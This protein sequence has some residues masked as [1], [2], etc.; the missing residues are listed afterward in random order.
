MAACANSKPPMSLASQGET[1]LSS[2]P[3]CSYQFFNFG[4][5][6]RIERLS[7]CTV[8]AVRSERS[9]MAKSSSSLARGCGGCGCDHHQSQRSNSNGEEYYGVS[10]T[11]EDQD[12]VKVLR[13]SQPYI[14]VHRGR[15]FV[16]VISAEIV[17]SPYLDPILKVCTYTTASPLS[18]SACS[19]NFNSISPKLLK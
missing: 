10:V 3:T 2:G 12:F 8:A 14:S 15:V 19:H 9:K 18:F 5:R 17:A 13:E 1:R 11:E 16:L 7:C 6:V 4:S